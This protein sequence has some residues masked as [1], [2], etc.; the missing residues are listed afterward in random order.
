MGIKNVIKTKVG[1]NTYNL[2]AITKNK[3]YYDFTLWRISGNYIVKKGSETKENITI[4]LKSNCSAYAD[5]FYT[6]KGFIRHFDRLWFE[7]KN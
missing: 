3:K 2:K 6:S 4:K 7:G 5:S 1:N